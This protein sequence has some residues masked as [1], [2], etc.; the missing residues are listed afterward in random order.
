MT[1]F[2]RH[3]FFRHGGR[4]RVVGGIAAGCALAA[5]LA[6]GAFAQTGQRFVT[7][8]PQARSAP[9]QGAPGVPAGAPAPAGL[10]SPTPFPQGLPSPQPYPAGIPSSVIA[11][12]GSA[13]AGT[14]VPGGTLVDRSGALPM[15]S[16]GVAGTGGR[17]LPA[18]DPGPYTALQVAQS[19]RLAD[20]NLDGEL[21][22]GE[23]VRLSIMPSSF[24]EMDRNKDGVLSRSEYEDALR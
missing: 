14:T 16:S 17:G 11:P 19:F 21:T 13:A 8:L 5:M 15:T 2:F 12:P 24:E 18:S 1:S 6:D 9:A 22:R 4:P 10:A 7:P 3:A 23:A 20:A